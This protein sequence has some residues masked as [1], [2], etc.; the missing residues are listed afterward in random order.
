MLVLSIVLV[1]FIIYAIF[2]YQRQQRYRKNI[3]LVIHV[4]GTRGK[5]SVTRL[6][7]AGL[8]AGNIKTIAKTT[9][10]APRIILENGNEIP[11]IRYFGPNIKE[12]L[13]IF[14]FASK[15]NIKAL[16]LE[17]MAINPEYQWITEQKITKSDIGVITNI[18]PDHLDVMGPG[19][20]NVAYSICNTLP[21]NGKAFTSEQ[22]LFPIMKK[23]AEKQNIDLQYVESN[24]VSDE[25]MKGFP[26]IEH[27]ENVAL[28]WE[29][30][31]SCGVKKEIALN[32]MKKVNPDIGATKLFLLKDKTK[33]IYFAHSFAA[34]DP[35]STK[36]VMNYIKNMDIDIEYTGIILNTRADR[37]FRSKQLIKMLSEIKF[38]MLYLIGEETARIQSYALKHKIYSDKICNLG[39]IE[40]ENLIKQV[41]KVKSRKILLIG[42]GNIGG[43]GR[44][45]VKYFSE[46]Q[47][48]KPQEHTLSP[49]RY[50]RD[51][52]ARLPSLGG[53]G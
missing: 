35:E 50:N 23:V 14:R 51:C 41:L 12:Q 1:I 11:I 27:K 28:A 21:K 2:E 44:I 53:Q 16:V 49:S 46:K 20:K 4:N 43:N 7:A 45:I 39:W 8:Q 48:N 38:N 47:G 22:K 31:N 15:R 36:F 52:E 19:I 25:D 5:S 6:I 30:C 24:Y 29:V 18:R 32:G 34:N 9:G 33:E 37:M 26:Y 10:S 3:P 17:C 40:G 13:K 42:I